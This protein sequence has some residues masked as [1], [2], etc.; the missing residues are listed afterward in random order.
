MVAVKWGLEPS[1]GIGALLICCSMVL[2]ATH[3][4]LRIALTRKHSGGPTRLLVTQKNWTGE[5]IHYDE[6]LPLGT[7]TRISTKVEKFHGKSGTARQTWHHLFLKLS[8]NRKEIFL[9]AIPKKDDA[10]KYK[11]QIDDFFKKSDETQLVISGPVNRIAAWITL[12]FGLF[13][14]SLAAL[15]SISQY[16]I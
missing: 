1:A 3:G 11:S 16:F 12:L 5:K 13:L 8:D 15:L 9:A 14:T 4:R 7:T 2:F 10:E 6:I